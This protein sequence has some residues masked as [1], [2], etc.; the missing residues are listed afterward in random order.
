MID[1]GSDVIFQEKGH[2]YIH[3]ESGKE[4]ISTN[5]LI[6]LYKNPFDPDGSILKKKAAEREISEKELQKEWTEK[7]DNA[8]AFGVDFHK[9]IEY[10]INKKKI[11]KSPHSEGVKQ[12]S[13]IKFKGKLQSELRI[14]NLDL[15]IAGTVDIIDIYK[16]NTINLLDIKTNAKIYEY[17]P[18]AKRMFYPLNHLIDVNYNHYALQMSVYCY[19]LDCAG[20]W[21]N[22]LIMLHYN[23]ETQKLKKY[24]IEYKKMDVINMINHYKNSGSNKNQDIFADF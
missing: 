12:F 22:D 3:V 11:R 4:L 15:G 16:D 17:A 9:E 5:S 21:I 6:S 23:K 18:W 2:K 8:C 10:Y 14:F 13:K 24:E 7:K 19:I 1:F 20:Y